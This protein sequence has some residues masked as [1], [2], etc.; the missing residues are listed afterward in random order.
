MS[1]MA[2]TS[3]LRSLPVVGQRPRRLMGMRVRAEKDDKPKGMGAFKVAPDEPQA[4]STPSE[5]TPSSSK[6]AEPSLKRQVRRL[7]Q[8]KHIVYSIDGYTTNLSCENASRGRN[9]GRTPRF[10]C[11][12]F[13]PSA[14][15]IRYW[16]LSLWT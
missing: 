16:M 15:P 10:G 1:A 9:R 2:T 7:K 14:L 13:F 12:C 4:S 8:N 6:P 11:P 3:V 5:A